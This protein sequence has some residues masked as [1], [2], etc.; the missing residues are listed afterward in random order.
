MPLSPKTGPKGKRIV[1]SI[2]FHHPYWMEYERGLK[3]EAARYGMEIDVHN[4]DW[5]QEHQ[6]RLVDKIIEEPPDL[7]I[8]IPVDPFTST[9]LLR[10]LWEKHI[11]VIGSNQALEEE[12]YSYILSWTGPNDWGQHRMLARCFAEAMEFKGGY[13]IVS[14]RPGTSAFNARDGRFAPS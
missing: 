14:H 2:P 10:R 13:C 11:P 6:S 1:V 7:V 9:D 3:K 8:F 12:A 5:D 4:S